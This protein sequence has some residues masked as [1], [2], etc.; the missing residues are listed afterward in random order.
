MQMKKARLATKTRNRLAG[1]AFFSPWLI[2]FVFLTA[3]PLIYSLVI[4]FCDLRIKVTGID[5]SYVG[6]SH[7]RYALMQDAVFPTKLLESMFLI[8]SGL[9]IVMVFALI[10]ALLLNRQFPGRTLFRAIFF[11]PVIIMSGPVLL[12]LVQETDAMKLRMNYGILQQYLMRFTEAGQAK[13]LGLF[14]DNLISTLWFTGVQTIVF[15]AVLQKIDTSMYEAASI[16]GATGWEMFWRIT[17]PHLRPAIVLN[18]IYS[19]VEMGSISSDG[20]NAKIMSHL[21]EVNRPY[22]YSA[23]MAWVYALAQLLL[24]GL[25]ALILM[26]K[27]ERR[28]G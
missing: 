5:L 7:Y 4:S 20:T 18:A 21:L 13:Y 12:Q 9:P 25:T 22:S 28:W 11:L 6:F 15:L 27:K 16:D 8:I 17:L 24:I 19:I 3:Y 2:G 23:A 10:I 1:M 26:E 14:M